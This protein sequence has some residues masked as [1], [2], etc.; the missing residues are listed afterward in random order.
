MKQGLPPGSQIFLQAPDGQSADGNQP[1]FR[2]LSDGPNQ[3]GFQFQLVQGQGNNLGDSQSGGI[4]DFQHGRIPEAP[5]RS[6]SWLVQKVFDFHPG[7]GFG[8][9]L[10]RFWGLEREEG[11]VGPQSFFL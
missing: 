5:G 6:G 11:I 9:R 8:Q 1:F 2:P 4:Q 3:L 10:F 7:Q